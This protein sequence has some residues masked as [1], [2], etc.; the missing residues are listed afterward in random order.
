MGVVTIMNVA[1]RLLEEELH[2]CDAMYASLITLLTYI[3]TLYLLA[4]SY[5]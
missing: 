1:L 3:Y 2:A 5:W 4:I